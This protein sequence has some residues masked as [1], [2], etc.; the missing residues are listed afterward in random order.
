MSELPILDPQPLQDL[1][2]LGAETGLVQELIALYVEDVPPRIQ[3]VQEGLVT[4]DLAKILMEA[5][6]MKGALSNLGLVRFADL[7]ARIEGEARAGR[8]EATPAIIPTLASAY[9][10]ALAAM[11]QAFPS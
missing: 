7:A 2:D 10:E 3:A 5:H 8:L 11:N 4:G 1:L 9:D 6:Q